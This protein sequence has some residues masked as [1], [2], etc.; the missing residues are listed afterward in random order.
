MGQHIQSSVEALRHNERKERQ[1]VA[2]NVAAGGKQQAPLDGLDLVGPLLI[3]RRQ[4]IK[5]NEGNG[6]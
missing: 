5:K 6:L 4:C 1:I 2:P 3:A